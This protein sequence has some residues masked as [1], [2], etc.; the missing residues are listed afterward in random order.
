M[1]NIFK[2]SLLVFILA[3]LFALPS[4][5][6]GFAQ[7]KESSN[8]SILG[9]S[10]ENTYVLP[11]VSNKKEIKPISSTDN[12]EIFDQIEFKIGLNN[13]SEQKYYDVIPAEY[14]NGEYSF[15]VVAPK[16][17]LEKDVEFNLIT[18]ELTADMEVILP[19]G[20]KTKSVTYPVTILV[21]R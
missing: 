5:G 8:R 20:F 15:I 10:D 6:F 2:N 16:D 1:K 19:K 3:G 21:V 14:L 11:V 7:Y 4:L 13:K 12:I 18:N 17:L 9:V